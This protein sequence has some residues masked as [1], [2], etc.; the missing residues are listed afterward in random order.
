M[1]KYNILIGD[2]DKACLF[3]LKKL[4]KFSNFEI[5]SAVSC[6]EIIGLLKKNKFDCFLFD[7]HFADGTA[8]ELCRVIRGDKDMKKAPIMIHS[9]Y[10]EETTNGYNACL[11][12]M[13]VEKGKTSGQ[14]PELIKGL[15]KRQENAKGVSCNSDLILDFKTLSVMKGDKTIATLSIEQFSFFSLLVE[16]APHCV[17][18]EAVFK[19]VFRKDDFTD[20]KAA[21]RALICRLRHKLGPKIS[22]RIK[23]KR[24][25]GW[26]YS[27]PKHKNSEHISPISQEKRAAVFH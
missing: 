6:K 13:F 20:K 12:D 24:G 8:L 5:T 21:L 25:K 7:Y 17:T 2:D 22:R 3:F 10:F 11:V 14:I 4:F 19:H 16:N 23:N 27:Q 1:K 26:F 18:E 9:G 15:L